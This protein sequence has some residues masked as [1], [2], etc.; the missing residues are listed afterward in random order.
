[1]EQNKIQTILN[2]HQKL[3]QTGIKYIPND[4]ERAKFYFRIAE[5]VLKELQKI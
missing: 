2:K 5:G 1:L 3:V 4:I